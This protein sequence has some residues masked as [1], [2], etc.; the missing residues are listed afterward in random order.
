MLNRPTQ[1]HALVFRSRSRYPP[2]GQ[3]LTLRFSVTNPSIAHELYMH[4]QPDARA[5]AR[6]F[7]GAVRG[8]ALAQS[9]G[10][11]LRAQLQKLGL[12]AGWATV[13]AAC[14]GGKFEGTNSIAIS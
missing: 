6:N 8:N 1:A 9:C 10:L 4:L 7:P 5:S 13:L 2:D 14:C 3:V 12:R 11:V